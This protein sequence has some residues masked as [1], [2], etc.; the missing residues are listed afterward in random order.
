MSEA[1]TNTFGMMLISFF[2]DA[3]LFGIGGLL[4]F[5][6]FRL[7]PEDPWRV[8]IIVA[9]LLFL[10]TVHI[11]TFFD[12]VYWDLITIFGDF[13]RLDVM[14]RTALVQLLAIYVSAFISQCF[15]ATRV[16]K[17]SRKNIWFTAIIMSLA[18]T[19]IISG[20]IQTTLSGLGG[21]FSHLVTTEK[22]TTIQSAATAACDFS[23][24]VILCWVF[25]GSRTGIQRTDT[26]L[27]KLMIYAINRGALTTI[28]AFLNMLLFVLR[29]G[30]FIFMVPLL[31]SG[32]LYLI[33]VTTTLNARQIMRL[34]SPREKFN[35]TIGSAPTPAFGVGYPLDS[36]VRSGNGSIP[37]SVGNKGAGIGSWSAGKV[38]VE[39]IPGGGVH[40]T[41]SVLTWCPDGVDEEVG[42]DIE[43]GASMTSSD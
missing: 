39:E 33:S 41:R 3:V 7:F 29:P 22:V 10:M 21:T 5:Q 24:T 13:P 32:Q 26:L 28:A 34:N 17:L 38:G 9:T 25:H 16:Y 14:P 6:Y 42:M 37:G 11:T 1:F 8:K 31:P 23:I 15:F 18:L 43:K 19:Q 36:V 30:T 12:W 2:L 40:V 27:D 4:A 20:I 35:T